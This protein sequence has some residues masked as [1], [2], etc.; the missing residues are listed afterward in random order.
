MSDVF[1]MELNLQILID[2]CMSVDGTLGGP[3]RGPQ[4]PQVVEVFV[5][6]P[7]LIYADKFVHPRMSGQFPLILS[8]DMMLKTVYKKELEYVKF[9]KPS[10]ETFDY[11]AEMVQM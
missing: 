7:D 3:Q 2:L 9:G 1:C 5:T 6:N 4:D 10:R 11:A 8:L